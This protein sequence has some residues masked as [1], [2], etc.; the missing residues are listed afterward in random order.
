MPTLWT[1]CRNRF[2]FD[3]LYMFITHKIIFNGICRPIAW[4]DRHIIDGSMDGL[5]AIT[6]KA[7]EGIK[8]LQSGNVQHYVYVYVAGAILLG[9]IT[10]FC[11]L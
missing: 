7:S 11:I 4:F 6:N 9:L 10:A 2:Y 1:W 5:A 8:C 3:E